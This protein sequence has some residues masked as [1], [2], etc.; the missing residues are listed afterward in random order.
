[1]ESHIFSEFYF[2][3]FSRSKGLPGGT[4]GKESSWWVQSLGWEDLLE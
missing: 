1:M 4:S 3:R 2:E